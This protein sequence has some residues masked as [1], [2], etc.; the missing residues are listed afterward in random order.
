VTGGKATPLTLQVAFGGKG[1]FPLPSCP[2]G[3]GEG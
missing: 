3:E 2:E 1:N